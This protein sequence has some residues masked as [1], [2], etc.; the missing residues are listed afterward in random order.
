MSVNVIINILKKGFIGIFEFINVLKKS[1][2]SLIVE[3]V[4]YFN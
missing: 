1:S 2:F 3:E 4:F